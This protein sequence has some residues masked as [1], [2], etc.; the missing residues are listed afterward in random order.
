MGPLNISA[1][2]CYSNLL[3]LQEN[4]YSVHIKGYNTNDIQKC[5]VTNVWI[6]ALS[7]LPNKCAP[8]ISILG[9]SACMTFFS[10]LKECVCD[11]FVFML[12]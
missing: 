3:P 7:S 10:K 6:A 1:Y 2:Q 9:M 5:M 4:R 12:Q 11:I 8:D